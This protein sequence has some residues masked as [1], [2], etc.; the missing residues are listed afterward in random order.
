MLQ[1]DFQSDV[2]Y[3]T[4][5]N[6]PLEIERKFL[7]SSF[8]NLAGIENLTSTARFDTHQAV[9]IDICGYDIRQAY[10]INTPEVTIRVR[11]EDHFGPTG[12]I[13][14]V[15]CIKKPV[16]GSMLVREEEQFD[17]EFETASDIL[18][19]LRIEHIIDKTRYTA[20]GFDIDLFRGPLQGLIIVEREFTSV[21]EANA[22]EIP[23]WAE[24]DVTD[25]P[26]YINSNLIGKKYV[27]G[28]LHEYNFS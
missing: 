16:N 17:M 28:E 1:L 14:T 4:R 10:I 8:E 20:D 18:D 25:D 11:I 12:G 3:C 5:M 23:H 9:V 21:E 15:L 24:R 27:N 7:V 19:S 13:R 6:P 22:F 2:G 26:A